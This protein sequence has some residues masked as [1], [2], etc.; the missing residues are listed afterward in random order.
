MYHRIADLTL[1]PHLLAVTPQHFEEHLEVVKKLFRPVPLRQVARRLRGGEP[2]RRLW[3]VEELGDYWRGDRLPKR[4][5]VLTFD[6]GFADNLYNAKPLLERYEC[7]VTVFVTA[8]HAGQDREFWWD[9]LERQLLEPGTLPDPLRLD[10]GG[11]THEWSF[12]E[13]AHYKPEDYARDRAWNGGL[14]PTHRR[15]EIW[16]ELTHLL[17]PLPDIEQR[18]VLDQLA[19]ASGK[20][21]P[22]ATHRTMTEDEVRQ[23]ENGGLVEIGAHT[24][25]H[26]TLAAHC[27]ELQREEIEQSKAC[28]ER[29]LDKPVRS[30]AFPF[31]TRDDYTAETVWILE[32][33]GFL[34]SCT[35][36]P[37]L[38]DRLNDPL[39]IP[40]VAI[41]DCDGDVFRRQLEDWFDA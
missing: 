11:R 17:R 38:V 15:Q 19:A 1:D 21:Q 36:N 22:R 25:T 35:T 27:A 37:G 23:L 30:F 8:G 6:D 14:E 41:R 7:P 33:A 26:P 39:Q 3:G 31:G 4:G 34:A 40:R 18:Q 9:E 2:A 5:V 28:L 16:V 29:M 10:V 24:M 20:C 32:Q 12:E 13:V